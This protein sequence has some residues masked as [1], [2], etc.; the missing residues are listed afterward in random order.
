MYDK[1]VIFAICHTL[2]SSAFMI[3]GRNQANSSY[4]LLAR[5][6]CVC[7]CVFFLKVHSALR[8]GSTNFEK[9]LF[10]RESNKLTLSNT[11]LY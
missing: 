1:A 4:T 10:Q 7:E 2:E 11:A 3:Q 8:A 6:V 9:L 5:R